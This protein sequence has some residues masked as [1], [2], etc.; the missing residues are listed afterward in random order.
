MIANLRSIPDP[1]RYQCCTMWQCSPLLFR[2]LI[3]WVFSGK[4]LLPLR[5]Q[6]YSPKGSEIWS[7]W[8]LASIQSWSGFLWN[9][10]RPQSLD[11]S[12]YSIAGQSRAPWGRE[13]WYHLAAIT[14]FSPMLLTSRCV[15]KDA[16]DKD[17]KNARVLE[18][19]EIPGLCSH[20]FHYRRWR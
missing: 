14:S 13:A 19:S 16:C 1:M 18:C 10:S 4:L 2:N 3:L 12:D 5:S 15:S 17:M 8:S 7:L 20:N 9:S 11:Y 6:G